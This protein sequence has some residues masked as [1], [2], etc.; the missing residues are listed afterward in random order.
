M[1]CLMGKS[2]AGKD[3]LYKQ[4]MADEELALRPIVSYTTR[5]IRVGEQDG[6][7]YHFTD[8]SGYLRLQAENRIIEARSY[9][10]VHGRWRYFT[11]AD[12]QLD[13]A[14][15]YCMIGTLEAYIS[16]REY[17]GSGQVI[18]VLIELDDGERLCRALARERAQEQPRY[19]EMCRR[20]LADCQD[21]DEERIKE[22][23]I[24]RRFCND[25]LEQ[26]REEIRAYIEQEKKR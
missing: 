11:V 17:F 15:D 12:D 13:L 14:E 19:E 16:L 1:I 5:P 8:E 9:E 10:T 3:S 23:G 7:E 4:L 25:D 6:V 22:A 24:V 21:F 18:P 26:C 20:F 2:G